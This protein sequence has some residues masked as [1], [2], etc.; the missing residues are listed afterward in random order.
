MRARALVRGLDA[1]AK[2]R[3]VTVHLGEML[4]VLTEELPDRLPRA[5]QILA[6]MCHG[7]GRR[8]ARAMIGA[9]ALRADRPVANAIEV[10]RTSEYV[11][12]VNPNHEVG[13]D[14]ARG[15]GFIDGDACPW[16]PRPG[17][18]PIHCGIFGQFQAGVCEELGLSYKL[19][20]TIPKHGGDRCRVDLRP[21]RHKRDGRPLG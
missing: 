11:F 1:E 20:T 17:W 16:Y 19:T 15:E 9:L 5:R 3:E 4:I 12:R 14:E 18:A 21:L 10:L 2:W 13:A 7:M 8:Y 6:T